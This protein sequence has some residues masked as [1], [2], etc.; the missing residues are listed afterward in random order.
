M[1]RKFY[2][3]IIKKLQK[4]NKD[5]QISSDFILGYPGE[6]RKKILKKQSNLSKK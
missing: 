6:D 3:S 5:I 2:L 1:N 4:V